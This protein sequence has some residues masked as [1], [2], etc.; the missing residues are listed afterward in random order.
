MGKILFITG[1]DTGVG[2]T[3][4][5]VGLVRALVA[6]GVSL[7]VMK[8]VESGCDPG[9]DGRPVPADATQLWNAAGRR[10]S[11]DEVCLYRLRA[12]VSP[13]V[14]AR[15]EGVR[16]DCDAVASAIQTQAQNADIVVVEGAGGLLVPLDGIYTFADL[17]RDVSATC[18][19]VVASRLGALNHA[20]LTFE[21]LR[22]R[23]IPVA[24]YVLNLLH[25]PEATG[26]TTAENTNAESLRVIGRSYGIDELCEIPYR[27]PA[28]SEPPTEL[29]PLADA[30]LRR[31]A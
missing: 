14:A 29:C 2:K 4:T 13:H 9:A 27:D 28:A 10:Q 8:P 18:L 6:S 22:A 11:L 19:V 12:P 17:A 7:R 15:A 31:L 23:N 16:V 1:T 26:E 20:A 3:S 21:V 30:I 24:G 25:P 5:A